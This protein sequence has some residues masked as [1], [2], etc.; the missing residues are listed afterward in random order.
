MFCHV[1][2]MIN[3]LKLL[4]C[5]N[6]YGEFSNYIRSAKKAGKEFDVDGIV[7]NLSKLFEYTGQMTGVE[8]NELGTYI[9]DFDTNCRKVLTLYKNHKEGRITFDEVVAE[10]RYLPGFRF[11]KEDQSFEWKWPASSE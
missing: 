5:L 9:E 6:P 10:A 8:K 4:L 7:E 2:N 3:L 11:N 1:K